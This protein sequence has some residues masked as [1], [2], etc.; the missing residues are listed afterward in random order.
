MSH[1]MSRRYSRRRMLQAAGIS[2]VG[3]TFL[4]RFALS[5]EEKKLNF[6]NFDTYIG[7]TTLADFNKATGIEVK[8]D[9]FAD[10]DELFS[11]LKA[12]NPGYDV[13][14]PSDRVVERMSKANM[15]MPLNKD[16]IPNLVNVD[17][18]FLKPSFDPER[19][20]SVPYMWGTVGLGYRKS[21]VAGGTLTSWKSVFE[22][23]ANAGRVSLLGDQEHCIGMALKY[24]GLPYN[25]MEAADLAKA[26][27]L[28]ISGKKIVKKYAED[29]GQELLA[30]GEV[31]IAM[32]Y[33][34][35]I[36]QVM[37]EDA[38]IAYVIPQ[39]GANVWEDDLCIPV[40]APHPENAHAFINYIFDPEVGKSVA[41]F[42]QYATPN[43]KAKELT[44]EKYRT[45][46]AIF[47]PAEILAKCE[48]AAYLG[49]EGA[50]VRDE[51]W[52]AIQAA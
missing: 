7:E 16:K 17:P 24:L 51:I 23:Q 47:P 11:K 6:Y 3:M 10:S 21:K 13:I 38:D 49:E 41:E 12:G 30:Q 45:N 9:L 40:G 42:I 8:L 52:T 25:S 28:L 18:G 37:A 50:K 19:K 31:D 36:A 26:K 32:E 27:D 14:V 43:L 48:Y 15:L 34:G 22:D 44:D 4:P 29:N 35:D 33:N 1:I 5:E 46:P 39:E 20:F 2:A